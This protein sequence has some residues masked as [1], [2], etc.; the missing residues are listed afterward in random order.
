[1]S[2]GA[3]PRLPDDPV[4]R[5]IEGWMFWPTSRLRTLRGAVPTEPVMPVLDNA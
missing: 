3:E 1:M 5:L 2:R 4:V